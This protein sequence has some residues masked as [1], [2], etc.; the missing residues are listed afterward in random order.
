[1]GGSLFQVLIPLICLAAF[2]KQRDA[3]AAAVMLWWAGQSLIDLAPYIADA[4]A[5]RMTLLGGVTGRDAPGY[6]D[7]HNLLTRTGLLDYDQALA[8]LTDA[9]GSALIIGALLWSGFLLREL[10]S[11]I[12]RESDPP[13]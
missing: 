6:H 9:L 11:R 5:Q 12:Q 10:R 3:F 2:L 1:M 8:T 4:G 7:W 13:G